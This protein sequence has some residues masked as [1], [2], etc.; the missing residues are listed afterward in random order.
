M[1]CLGTV[2]F[3][4]AD[5]RV[6]SYKENKILT[7]NSLENVV[8]NAVNNNNNNDAVVVESNAV[9]QHQQ[10]ATNGRTLGVLAGEVQK[11]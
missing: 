3:E 4:D 5:S 10:G 1:D 2:K 7:G 8:V 11:A 6:A 9:G